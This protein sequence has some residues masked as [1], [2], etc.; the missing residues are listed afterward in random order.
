MTVDDVFA[1]VTRTEAKVDKVLDLLSRDGQE[2]VRSW[3]GVGR[4]PPTASCE[5]CD[6][7][8]AVQ[9]FNLETYKSR[10]YC[11]DH[12]GLGGESA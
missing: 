3:D 2:R 12:G 6:K 5:R 10:W 11:R 9:T 1:K 8:A 4:A 7:P